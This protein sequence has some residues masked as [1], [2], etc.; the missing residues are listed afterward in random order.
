MSSLGKLHITIAFLFKSLMV[1][2]LMLVGSNA[3]AHTGHGGNS[4][5]QHAL[6]H[7]YMLLPLLIVFVVVLRNL[8]KKKMDLPANRLE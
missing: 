7:G 6:E 2:L 3:L 5:T 1:A 8:I 4:L